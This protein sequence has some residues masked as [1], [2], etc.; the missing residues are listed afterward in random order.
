[1]TM[2]LRFT[3]ADKISMTIV[4]VGIIGIIL[5]YYISDSYKQFAYQHHSQ[6]IQLPPGQPVGIEPSWL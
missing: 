2:G 4:V 3:L 5:V 6:V 1:M